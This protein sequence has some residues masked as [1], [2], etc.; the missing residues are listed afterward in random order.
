MFG[1]DARWIVAAMVYL[2][3]LCDNFTTVDKQRCMSGTDVFPVDWPV[4]YYSIPVPVGVTEPW[5]TCIGFL[6]V[7][8]KALCEW[9]AL[10][11]ATTKFLLAMF[12]GLRNGEE[13]AITS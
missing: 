4:A 9:F 12:G 5:P 13:L 3:S 2:E 11:R 7:F 10:A 8:P 1:I 6:Y